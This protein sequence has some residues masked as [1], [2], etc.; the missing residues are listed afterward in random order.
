MSRQ[1]RI[2][3]VPEI[4]KESGAR[5]KTAVT[6][7]IVVTSLFGIPLLPLIYPF[8][9]WYQKKFYDSLEVILTRRDLVVRLGV[10]NRQEKSIPLEKITDVALLEGPIMR[11]YGV[12]GLRVETA[13]QVSGAMGLVNL[14]GVGDPDGFRDRILE[15]RDRISDGDS[16]AGTLPAAVDGGQE[17]AAGRAGGREGVGPAPSAIGGSGLGSGAAAADPE[18]LALLR[19]IR[20]HLARL[21]R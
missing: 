7:L 8:T 18:V 2:L 4:L 3:H 20:D 6:T 1:I 19:E 17:A 21:E 14:V 9:R 10:W 12:K 16:G 5:Y 11:R 13:G 15:Q